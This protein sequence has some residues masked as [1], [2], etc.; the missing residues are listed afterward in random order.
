MTPPRFSGNTLVFD[1]E[2]EL[3][4]W[5]QRRLSAWDRAGR[6]HYLAFQDPQFA[7]WFPD[8]ENEGPPRAIFFVDR[9]HRLWVGVEAFRR[10]LPFLPFGRTLAVLFYLPGVPWLSRRI[11]EWIA[12]NRYRFRGFEN[13]PRE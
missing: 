11:Y 10:M 4:R 6:I 13:G 2:C 7:R 3:C 12:V 8:E 1:R 9:D 5:A